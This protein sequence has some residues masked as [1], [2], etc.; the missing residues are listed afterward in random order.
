MGQSGF[1]MC[2]K[3]QR[4]AFFAQAERLRSKF[5]LGVRVG[6]RHSCAM[7]SAK[8]RRSNTGAR[9]SDDQNMLAAQL[10]S[11]CHSFAETFPR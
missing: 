6:S 9:Q 3:F 2:P 10:E 7:L 8:T 5:T 11:A 1:R 4:D